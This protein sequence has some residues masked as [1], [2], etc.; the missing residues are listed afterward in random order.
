MKLLS[1]CY[2]SEIY[3]LSLLYYVIKPHTDTPHSL[4]NSCPLLV[5]FPLVLHTAI[6]TIFSNQISI[7]ENSL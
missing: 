3:I 4:H 2:S 6:S 1:D 5:I 7:Q